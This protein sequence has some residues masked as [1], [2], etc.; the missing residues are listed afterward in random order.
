MSFADRMRAI[1]DETDL[2]DSQEIAEKLLADMD[3]DDRAE[4]FAEVAVTIVSVFISRDRMHTERPD[5]EPASTGKS[6]MAG[7]VREWWGAELRKRYQGGPDES[8]MLGDFSEENHLY[9]AQDRREHAAATIARA[10]WHERC[11]KEMH[12]RKVKHFR[13]LPKTVLAELIEARRP[14]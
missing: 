11:A 5:R 1:L 13:L 8:L 2:V 7:A 6:K 10:E 3:D 9:A 14:E 4:A 12:A